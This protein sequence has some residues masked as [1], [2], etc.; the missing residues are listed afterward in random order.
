LSQRAEPKGE[1]RERRGD[2]K[3]K[4]GAKP[5]WVLSDT[6]TKGGVQRSPGGSGKETFFVVF[7]EQKGTKKNNAHKRDGGE[8]TEKGIAKKG[9]KQHRKAGEGNRKRQALA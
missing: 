8:K 3:P 2:E 4:I 9:E 5:K 6:R 1:Q 7:C